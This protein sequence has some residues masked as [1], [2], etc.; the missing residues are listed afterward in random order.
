[1]PFTCNAST[2]GQDPE[3]R[4][5]DVR[6]AARFQDLLIYIHR[7]D[8]R[9]LPTAYAVRPPLSFYYV[10]NM[11]VY[12]MSD[13]GAGRVRRRYDLLHPSTARSRSY[14]PHCSHAHGGSHRPAAGSGTCS[15]RGCGSPL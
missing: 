14:Q 11:L 15:H 1:M 6:H 4:I 13:T 7:A 12:C 2:V 10:G 8:C 3:H 5:H 9:Q